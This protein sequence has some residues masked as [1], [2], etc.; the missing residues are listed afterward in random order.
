MYIVQC[1]TNRVIVRTSVLAICICLSK[2][3][4]IRQSDV[5]NSKTNS[6]S[7]EAVTSFNGTQYSSDCYPFVWSVVHNSWWLGLMVWGRYGPV[8][9]IGAN[10]AN[11]L[12]IGFNS[13]NSRL[14]EIGFGHANTRQKNKQTNK[15]WIGVHLYYYET[16]AT[17]VLHM[18]VSMLNLSGIALW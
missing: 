16:C 12:L 11:S 15:H 2:C 5:R 6:N 1:F 7:S 8:R 18:Y 3:R 4:C 10:A 9:F 17:Y 13:N 14:V